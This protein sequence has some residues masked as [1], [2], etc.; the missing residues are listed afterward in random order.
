MV[1]KVK[2]VGVGL[3]VSAVKKKENKFTADRH[4]QPLTCP[5]KG[6]PGI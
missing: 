5:T 2:K 6:Y 4:R 3:R 1:L